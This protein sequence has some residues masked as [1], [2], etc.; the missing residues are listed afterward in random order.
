MAVTCKSQEAAIEATNLGVLG[1][2]LKPVDVEHLLLLIGRAVEKREARM[3]LRESEGRY[4]AVF[5]NSGTAMLTIEE[6]TSISLVNHGFE[7]LSGYCKEEIEGKKSWVEFVAERDLTRMKDYHG[8]RRR[9]EPA[10]REYEFRFVDRQGN[11]KDAYLNVGLIPGTM[12]SIASLRD[13]T[14]ERRTQD[15]LQE[16]FIDL[17]EIVARA[18]GSL[19]PYTSGHQRRVAR[20]ADLVG[21]RLDMDDDRLQG[22]Y[23]GALLHDI[24]KLS[25][26]GTLLTKPGRLSL[27]EWKVI[28]AHPRRGYD[29]LKEANLPWP[30]AEMA[31]R[32]HERLDGSGYPDGTKGPELSLELRILGVCDVVEAMS[33]DRPYRAARPREEVRQELI[34]GS[35]QRYDPQ[36]VEAALKVIE[37]GAFALWA[38]GVDAGSGAQGREEQL[39]YVGPVAAEGA[40]VV[41]RAVEEVGL[42]LERDPS[43]GNH[44]EVQAR[45]GLLNLPETLARAMSS[46]DPS[47]S[48]HQRRVAEFV[49]QVGSRLGLSAERLWG[50]RL[51]GLLHDVGKIAVP[52]II[53]SRPGRLSSE[54]LELVRTHPEEGYAILRDA[55]LPPVVPLMALHHHERLDG[56]GY[57]Q[58]LSGEALSMEDRILSVCNVVEAM[59]A[60]RPYRRGL[61]MKEVLTEIV[62]GRG[63]RYDSAVVECALELL[64]EGEFVLGE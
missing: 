17:V 6:D 32:H 56:S 8:E 48:N 25:V 55:G 40:T 23:V 52:E 59:G 39:T 53:L 31:L 57:P 19:D 49:E 27:Q 45:D 3:A 37:N 64:E 22:L 15:R 63:T 4:R 14:E 58:G 50:L 51:G 54:E 9:G 11:E 42:A 2:S 33:S 7:V 62:T 24:G 35:G 1:Y 36:V 20:L 61:E 47:T 13:I 34:A 28:R 10:P 43:N 16:S 41:E 44:T 21:S 30:V 26:P 38:S 5:E 60:H 18:M 46:R 29:I 12:K